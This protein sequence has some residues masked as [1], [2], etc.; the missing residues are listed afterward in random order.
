VT[1]SGTIESD[2]FNSVLLHGMVLHGFGG[3]VVRGLPDSLALL[4]V[5]LS[6]APVGINVWKRY[7]RHNLKVS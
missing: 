1:S 3:S 7:Y 4:A 6:L 2:D 5:M